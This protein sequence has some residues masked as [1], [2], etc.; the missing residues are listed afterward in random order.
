[1][2][3]LDETGDTNI[4]YQNVLLHLGSVIEDLFPTQE[5]APK[6]ATEIHLHIRQDC[7]LW[8][9]P[10]IQCEPSVRHPEV[11]I[12][13]VANKL[14][15][16]S[17]PLDQSRQKILT[18]VLVLTEHL[19]Y[20]SWDDQTL[21]RCGSYTL[22]RIF[23]AKLAQSYAG[24]AN[25][26]VLELDASVHSVFL[27]ELKILDLLLVFRSLSWELI[28]SSLTLLLRARPT[29]LSGVTDVYFDSVDNADNATFRG[30]AS[31]I[32]HPAV[33]RRVLRALKRSAIPLGP[34]IVQAAGIPLLKCLIKNCISHLLLLLRMEPWESNLNSINVASDREIAPQ[35]EP[36]AIT[37][38]CLRAILKGGVQADDPREFGDLVQ[39]LRDWAVQHKW[40][41]PIHI[42]PN[43]PLLVL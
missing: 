32:L 13:K 16:D 28:K 20:E 10:A 38:A 7:C 9:M 24:K 33:L 42:F 25:Q 31:V 29:S 14:L 15:Y 19:N 35:A 40:T 21:V 30:L 36:K 43:T 39:T 41:V 18:D 26:K 4:I 8:A 22:G 12:P 1:M 27:T 23:G 3:D 17:Q 37:E 11:R 2:L 6:E 34:N 5:M